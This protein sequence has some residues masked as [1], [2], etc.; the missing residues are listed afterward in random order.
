MRRHGG[1]LSR[2]ALGVAAAIVVALSTVA[3]SA[4]PAAAASAHLTGGGSGFA[5]PEIDQWKAE[6]AV[7]PYNLSINYVAQGSTFGRVAFYSETVDFGASDITYPS[8]E[9]GPLQSSRRCAGKSLRDCFVYVPVSAGGVALMYNLSDASGNRISNLRLTRRSA[10]KIFTGAIKQWNDPELVQ[11]NPFLRSFARGIQPVIRADGAGESYVLSQFCIA[12]APDVWRDFIARQKQE[13]PQ[14]NG[15]DFLAGDPVSNWPPPSNANAIPYA[16]GVANAVANPQGGPGSI[17]YVAAAYAKQ[18]SF[19]VASLQNAA[20]VFTQPDEENVTVAL[21]YARP[22]PSADAAG[23]FILD[24]GGRDTRSYFP[25]TY[26]YILSQRAGFDPSQ[27][28]A[29]G[30]FLCYAVSAGQAAAVPLKYARLSKPIVDIAIDAISKI[31]GAPDKA[32]CFIAGAAPPPPPPVV[33]GGGGAAAGSGTSGPVAGSGGVSGPGLSVGGP[34]A[35]GSSKLAAHAATKTQKAAAAAAARITA[36]LGRTTDSSLAQQN[37]DERLTA[38]ARDAKPKSKSISGI[39]VLVSGVA[40][41]WLL[42]ALASR[43]RASA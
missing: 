18:R 14:N 40:V 19:P 39:W 11:T 25:S 5:G 29:L 28:A 42:T 20:G 7:S 8:F 35:T 27:G 17:T 1:L 41:A 31:P 12:V 4:P 10:C 15:S 24:F 3:G 6:T 36:S 38:A 23:T 34:P 32:H 2:A 30:Q 13:N 43:R 26:S 33:S 9:V 16:D 21:G 22:N 37:L